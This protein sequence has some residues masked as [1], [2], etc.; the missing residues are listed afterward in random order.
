MKV[1]IRALSQ[2]IPEGKLSN[3]N[4]EDLLNTTQQW[5]LERVGIEQRRFMSDYEGPTPVFHSSQKAFET[6][7]KDFPN[8]VDSI[9]YIITANTQ[10]D[11]H[12]P[13]AANIVSK[14]TNL[15]VPMFQLKSAC[16]SVL[17]AIQVARSLVLTKQANNVL[18]L[19]GE[20]MTRFIDMGD[21]TSSILFGDGAT[22]L[23][24]SNQKGIFEVLDIKT[25]GEGADFVSST[26]VSNTSTM[27]PKEFLE[28][29]SLIGRPSSSSRR[30]T[31]Q[32]F[33][34]DGKQV[35]N[36]VLEKIP[37]HIDQFMKDNKTKITELDNF[38]SHQSNM[39]MM[40]KLCDLIQM[41]RKKMLSNI[42]E[43]GN[44]GSSGWVST[45]VENY[46]NVEKNGKVLVSVFGAGMTWGNLLIKKD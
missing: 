3:K 7:C 10:D 38:I 12:Y 30:S 20:P 37:S 33:S 6:L 5:I 41:D 31:D 15:N 11:L 36:F 18:I 27:T 44:T 16:T 25:G 29:E 9:D 8:I 22:A 1:F 45:L 40:N 43:R 2:Y 23:V 19:N 32:K 46:K 13:N 42:A 34:Q 14:T 21:R 39:T 28:G 4:F 17:Y 35:V 26:R 24:I